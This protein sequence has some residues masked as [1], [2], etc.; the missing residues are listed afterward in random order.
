MVRSFFAIAIFILMVGCA[1]SQTI[2]DFSVGTGGG[3]DYSTFTS[4]ETNENDSED[5][6]TNNVINR[7]VGYNDSVFDE[8]VDVAGATAVSSTQYFV[9]T[10]A[11]GER[12]DGTFGS[13]ARISRSSG[14]DYVIDINQDFTRVEYLELQRTTG[15]NNAILHSD[16]AGIGGLYFEY[17][18]IDGGG[19]SD[20]VIDTD[21]DANTSRINGCAIIDADANALIE[22]T[23]GT[24][25]I[26]YT[27]GYL[28][29]S[30]GL[31]TFAA[32]TITAK[33]V[34]M[35]GTTGNSFTN[36]DTPS[37]LIGDDTSPSGTG[38][39]DSRTITASTSPG[40]G[41]WVIVEN[42]TAGSENL[43]LVSNAEN[44]AE[45]A[46]DPVSGIT[47]DHDGDT[48]ANPPD[49]GYDEI[50]SGGGGGAYKKGS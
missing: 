39:L 47:E 45:N 31:N 36:I 4:C 1:A 12:H 43:T 9:I 14:F 15:G 38:S 37:Y 29:G 2:N 23:A 21:G 24:W 46:G 26:Y 20:R 33:N 42:I 49:I 50:A 8:N 7:C 27:S 41:D 6:V 11:S 10:V 35:L 5:Y 48:I 3:R 17:L 34:W 13:G 32:A 19:A 44:D 22:I 40:S 30:V 18:L 25:E 28:S 16:N